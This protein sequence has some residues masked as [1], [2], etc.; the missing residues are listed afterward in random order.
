MNSP[1]PP[2]S[3][4][5]LILNAIARRGDRHEIHAQLRPTSHQIIRNRLALH[6][7]EHAASR[8]E[9]QNALVHLLRHGFEPELNILNTFDRWVPWKRKCFTP[10][11]V[12]GYALPRTKGAKRR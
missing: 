12:L 9:F 3:L 11:A 5:G 4:S 2:T 8:A 10:C 1:F 7:R 6:S